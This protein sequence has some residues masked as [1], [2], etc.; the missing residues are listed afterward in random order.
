M[1]RMTMGSIKE[2]IRERE[3]DFSCG[4]QYK[5]FITKWVSY[6]KYVYIRLIKIKY[7][8]LKKKIV[9]VQE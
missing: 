8:Y 1:K 6:N 9:F 2:K 4:I 5:I 7:Y 3:P